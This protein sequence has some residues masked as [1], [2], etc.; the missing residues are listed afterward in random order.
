MP[1]R[2][3]R[4]WQRRRSAK[5]RKM[6]QPT[7]RPW[8]ARSYAAARPPG[9]GGNPPRQP[10]SQ[11]STY[12]PP[13][14]P[15]LSPPLPPSAPA[16]EPPQSFLTPA[17]LPPAPAAPPLPNKTTKR[18]LIAAAGLVLAA[19]IVGSL[20]SR[21]NLK[22][23]QNRTHTAAIEATPIVVPAERP[24]I[25][26]VP[27]TPEAHAPKPGESGPDDLGNPEFSA[28]QTLN[29][30]VRALWESGRYARRWRS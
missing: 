19:G 29:G 25:R 8:S 28:R 23:S 2:R 1:A 11:A 3:R 17:A 24:A 26:P 14:P 30:P 15:P 10:V 27:V 6:P 12:Q 21:Q 7:S 5:G 18:V 16:Y 22:A 4:R 9:A 20:V 13:A